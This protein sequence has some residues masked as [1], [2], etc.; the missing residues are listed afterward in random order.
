[1]VLEDRSTTGTGLELKVPRE[2]KWGGSGGEARGRPTVEARGR[3]GGDGG[4]RTG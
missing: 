2:S 1:M 4:G 3:A